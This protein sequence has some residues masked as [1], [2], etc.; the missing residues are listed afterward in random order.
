MNNRKA[1]SLRR[2]AR[3]ITVGIH[4]ASNTVAWYEREGTVDVIGALAGLPRQASD[5]D[6][7]VCEP[8]DH[9][10]VGYTDAQGVMTLS[11]PFMVRLA[12][13]PLPREAKDILSALLDATKYR[14]HN[15]DDHV[16]VGEG[17]TFREIRLDQ[18]FREAEALL[19]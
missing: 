17:D 11:A 8:V 5:C 7:L 9:E 4:R 13:V 6:Y 12:D 2:Q 15:A 19:K 1:K 14:I 10:Y 16:R 3:Q 18:L